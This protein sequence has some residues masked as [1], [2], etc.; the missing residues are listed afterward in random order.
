MNQ[1][2]EKKKRTNSIWTSIITDQR[3]NCKKIRIF[4]FKLCLKF[5][6]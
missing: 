4:N 5:K 3:A 1:P 6:I 2:T